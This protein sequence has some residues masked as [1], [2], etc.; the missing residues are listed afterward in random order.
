M[1]I[2]LYNVPGMNMV[3]M[4]LPQTGFLDDYYIGAIN[5]GYYPPFYQNRIRIN[6][7]EIELSQKGDEN[8]KAFNY[9][10][11]RYTFNL[12]GNEYTAPQRSYYYYVTDIEYVAENVIEATLTM[13]TLTTY[14]DCIKL[15]G[16]VIQRKAINRWKQNSSNA[17]IINRDYIPESLSEAGQELIYSRRY[18][19]G[20]WGFLI[21]SGSALA[22]IGGSDSKTADPV[23]ALS[24]TANGS[25]GE[26]SL[27]GTPIGS[28]T[29][30]IN[31]TQMGGTISFIPYVEDSAIVSIIS[32]VTY[33]DANYNKTWTITHE[34]C[35]ANLY[36][37]LSSTSN[38]VSVTPVPLQGIYQGF[39]F[40]GITVR[41]TAMADGLP[42]RVVAHNLAYKWSQGSVSV[43][44]YANDAYFATFQ[45]MF[46]S[47]LRTYTSQPATIN[48]AM[49]FSYNF[50][51]ARNQSETSL[52]NP[53]YVPA[54]LDDP[55]YKVVFAYNGMEAS[56]LLHYAL[57]NGTTGGVTIDFDGNAYLTASCNTVA[58]TGGQVG[59][60]SNS[61]SVV[62]TSPM[63]TLTLWTDAWEE[64]KV[65]HQGSIITDFVG[66]GLQGAGAGVAIATKARQSQ[67]LE[68]SQ[69]QRYEERTEA[70]RASGEG[71]ITGFRDL[72]KDIPKKSEIV[73]RDPQGKFRS[74]R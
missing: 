26:I 49:A 73:I 32:G 2:N 37:V 44:S 64:Y 34:G 10:E 1:S 27:Q 11:I 29:P 67:E 30:S 3:D 41:G 35:M 36:A 38:V 31:S 74:V 46:P 42:C 59:L 63:P 4:L 17:W 21:R 58:S 39:T 52:Y 13:D 16:M 48:N 20:S 71:Y 54:L 9:A 62:V 8:G 51:F 6:L 15:S 55:Y 50:S 12:N 53:N 61:L 70:I 18:T 72:L 45:Y 14:W 24:I 28:A 68:E 22:T 33:S 19:P 60:M 69:A 7:T 5:D 43:S 47:A 25:G 65:N 56:P 40:T 57:D 66:M 23:T